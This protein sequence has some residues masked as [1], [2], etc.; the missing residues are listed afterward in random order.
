MAEENKTQ[1]EENIIII[2]DEE[3]KNAKKKNKFTLIIIALLLIV[4]IL[5]LILAAVV[6]TKKKNKSQTPKEI[7]EITKKLEKKHTIPKDEIK[8]LIKRAAILYEK[9]DKIKALKILN[10]LASYSE[11]LS[12]YNLGVI[13][14]EEKNYKKALEYFQ[15][16]ITNKDNR[17]LSAINAAYASL[18]LKDKKL[19]NYYK[20]LAYTFL[21]EIAK[22][23]SYPYYYSIVMYYM[24]YE[25]E[26]LPALQ[27]ANP[28]AK[29]SKQL[30]SALYEYYGD[31][32]KARSIEENPFY[33]G[34]SFAKT[35]EFSLAKTY[36]SMSEKKESKFA[37]A[38]VDLKLHNYKETFGIL[39]KFQDNNIYPIKAYLK[40]SLFDT[41]TAQTEFKNNF[42]KNKKDYYDLFFY[43]APYK[44]FN[45]N[46]TIS[47][48]KK[49]IAGIPIGSIEES[50]N[51]LSK[52]ATYSAL[53][54]KISKALKLALNGHIYLA[55]QEFKKLIKQKDSSYI[56][57]YDLA[58]TY[59]QLGDYI[60][61]YKH[62]LR[63]YHLNPNDLKSGIYA[64]MNL[65]KMKKTNDYLVSSIK[66]DIGDNDPLT[67]ALLAITQNNTVKMAAFLEKTDKNTPTWI[68]AKLT[69]KALLDRDY[70][71]EALKLKSIYPNDIIS[72]LLYFYST[73]KNF[74][75]YKLALNYQSMF[76]S[77]KYNM[78]DFYY[79]TKIVR[80]WYFK[81][82]KI[83][84]LLNKVRLNLIQK[85]KKENFDL[86][87]VL[88]RV[89]FANLY[90]RHFEEAYV[91]YNDLINN[92]N[93]T[94][95]H[96]LYH[97]AVAAI[98]ANHHANA[99]VLMELA[100]LKNPS[101]YEARYGLGLLW[102]E[103]G[104]LRAAS[105][106]YSKIPDGFE[107]RFFDFNIR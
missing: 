96:T 99:V 73:N 72:N 53:N 7:T 98:G 39:K 30:L 11:A 80:D 88:K 27:T 42:L 70:T 20:N 106:Q 78:N 107:S 5:L 54:I 29:Q 100:K 94:D 77:H 58:L 85:A 26:T 48:L 91:L 31:F 2:E 33:K 19:F 65:E 71:Y 18:M 89:A 24:G 92:K 95:P 46:Q 12:Y 35:G 6:V 4:I 62:F 90:T 49:G 55:N 63:A 66:E 37:L 14:L 44:V 75:I 69:S 21:P 60:N 25:F 47:Y 43:Y 8:Q 64:L 57:H 79:G 87:P 56:L 68:L 74:P 36:L 59:A 104:N 45:I 9:G 41:K 16:A 97:A 61:A 10:K 52:S 67:E 22:L 34:I 76:F 105:I 50:R 84:G 51:Y 93:I 86:I 15:K 3:K 81:F 38:L 1:Q 40:S 13:K 82:A 23:K 28:Y 101:F 102:E 17:A 32:T 83:S 103:T